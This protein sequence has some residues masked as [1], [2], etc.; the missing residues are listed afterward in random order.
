MS[1]HGR[2]DVGPRDGYEFAYRRKLPL[3]WQIVTFF[4]EDA[5]FVHS[6]ARFW[7]P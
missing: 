5:C 4:M 1:D 3:F 6:P 2:L 7:Q